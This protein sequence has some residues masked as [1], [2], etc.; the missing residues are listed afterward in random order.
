MH[1]RLRN[2]LSISL[3]ILHWI[4]KKFFSRFVERNPCYG[5]VCQNGGTCTHDGHDHIDCIC[6]LGYEGERCQCKLF[7]KEIISSFCIGDNDIDV[8]GISRR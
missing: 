7:I 1:K 4:E 3:S 2:R 6:K 8:S 5:N